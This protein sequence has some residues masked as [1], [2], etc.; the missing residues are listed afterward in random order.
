VTVLTRLAPLDL[1]AAQLLEAGAVA[2]WR[3]GEARLRGAALEA[4]QRLPAAAVQ[5]ALGSD[6]SGLL[7]TLTADAWPSSAGAWQEV[8]RVG[9]FVGFGGDFALPPILLDGGDRHTLPCRTQRGDLWVWA[10]RYGAVARPV[11]KQAYAP[12]HAAGPPSVTQPSSVRVLGPG[13]VALTLPRS[14]VIRIWRRKP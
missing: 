2:A 14:H 9:A 13:L 8:A 1:T 3:L 6:D 12:A 11:D 5:I 4:A 10:D 7:A